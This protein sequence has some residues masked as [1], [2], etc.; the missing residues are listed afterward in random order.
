MNKMSGRMTNICYTIVL[1]IF[2]LKN[3]LN[4][5]YLVGSIT[6]LFL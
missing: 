5:N 4:F 6:K 2:E 1:E 3:I